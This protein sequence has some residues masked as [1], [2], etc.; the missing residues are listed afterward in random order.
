MGD[1]S[2]QPNI[3]IIK[4]CV[5]MAMRSIEEND[6]KRFALMSKKFG[7]QYFDLITALENLIE[8]RVIEVV[9]GR[10][11]LI[12][13]E[14]PQLFTQQIMDGQP[15]VWDLFDALPAKYRKFNPDQTAQVLLGSNGELAVMEELKRVV[16]EDLRGKIIRV[17]EI[18]DHYGYDIEFP[19]RFED[20][21]QMALEVKTTSR[22]G[23][24][25]RFYLTRNEYRAGLE[26]ANWN[27][28]FVQLIAGEYEIVGHLPHNEIRESVPQA[29]DADWTWESV[30]AVMHK[31]EFFPGLPE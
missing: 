12:G 9:D 1:M 7:E 23:D 10:L 29:R 25:F 16:P 31:S 15:W 2:T 26:L 5:D 4:R 30:T 28:V 21:G 8:D 27:L 11:R 14:D 20:K 19:S 24:Y 13:I 6:F 18:S 22:P 3:V 17:S